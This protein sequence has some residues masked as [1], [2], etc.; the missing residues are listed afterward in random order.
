MLIFGLSNP[1]KSSFEYVLEAFLGSPEVSWA[2]LA[3][4]GRVWG[5]FWVRRGVPEDVLEA[6]WGH[7]G[8]SYEDF[9]WVWGVLEAFWDAF[10]SIF[11]RFSAI[12]S[13]I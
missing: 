9:G 2:V 7:F 4:L 6:S 13:N 3:H 8:T 11:E 12:S 10:G 5:V 1:Q